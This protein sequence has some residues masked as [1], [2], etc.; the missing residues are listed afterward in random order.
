MAHTTQGANVPETVCLLCG[1]DIL[2]DTELRPRVRGAL[3]RIAE[4]G[5]RPVRFLFCRA[6]VFTALCLDE[7]AQFRRSFPGRRFA[8]T[9]VLSENAPE[10][11][12]GKAFALPPNSRGHAHPGPLDSADAKV[13]PHLLRVDSIVRAGGDALPVRER[14]KKRATPAEQL[15]RKPPEVILADEFTA[16]ECWAAAR[17]DWMV[18]YTYFDLLEPFNHIFSGFAY[19]CEGRA[20]LVSS[21][22]TAERA[23]YNLAY[24]DEKERSVALLLRN[25]R[26]ERAAEILGLTVGDVLKTAQRANRQLHE[27]LWW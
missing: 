15:F 23:F 25:Q 18:A 27:M 10:V 20:L 3:R 7:L 26:P 11:P 12:P 19:E 4:A 1:L 22:E 13:P 6:N 21:R 17:S 24:L 16:A 8:V 2:Y 5:S 9:L 14:K